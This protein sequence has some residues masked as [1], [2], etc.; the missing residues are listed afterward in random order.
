MDKESA[1]EDTLKEVA[2]DNM[3]FELDEQHKVVEAGRAAGVQFPDNPQNGAYVIPISQN[4]PKDTIASGTLTDTEG[5]S[6]T[7]KNGEVESQ[8]CRNSAINDKTVNSIMDIRGESS[9]VSNPL[10]LACETN[11]K[12]GKGTVLYFSNKG[13]EDDNLSSQQQQITIENQEIVMKSEKQIRRKKFEAK[14]RNLCIYIHLR[15]IGIALV[16]LIILALF[17]VPPTT[18]W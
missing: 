17:V 14:L 4:E 7:R 3:A 18:T 11:I 10:A 12:P 13:F 2:K 9:I 15:C 8:Q 5:M 6:A 1:M 16:C